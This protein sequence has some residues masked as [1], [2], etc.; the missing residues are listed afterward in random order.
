MELDDAYS[1]RAF[2]YLVSR[3]LGAAVIGIDIEFMSIVGMK[4]SV[5]K[6][7]LRDLLSKEL[8]GEEVAPPSGWLSEE[9][10]LSFPESPGHLQDILKNKRRTEQF[11]SQIMKWWKGV[12]GEKMGCGEF[13]AWDRHVVDMGSLPLL[14]DQVERVRGQLGGFTFTMDN[15]IAWKDLHGMHGL[16]NGNI[17]AVKVDWMWIEVLRFIIL[18]S[19]MVVGRSIQEGV[20]MT[21][22]PNADDFVKKSKLKLRRNSRKHRS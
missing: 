13:K 18:W 9:D 10:K 3:G 19:Y 15:I 16:S 21:W 14:L 4:S 2:N 6:R 11:A 22:T 8:E 5:P 1:A 7:I 17:K 20:N 12:R